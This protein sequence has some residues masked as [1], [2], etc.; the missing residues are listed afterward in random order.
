MNKQL[1]FITVKD[2]DFQ[3]IL[4]ALSP[5]IESYMVGKSTIRN[6]VIEEYKRA[7]LQVK[8]VLAKAKLK[9]H[10]SFDL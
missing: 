8:E 1:L 2:N 4:L 3:Q 6:W 9:I 5:S 7:R 10:I